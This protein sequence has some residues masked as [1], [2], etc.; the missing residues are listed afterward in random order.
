MAILQD[1]STAARRFVADFLDMPGT[2]LDVGRLVE[3][4]PNHDRPQTLQPKSNLFTSKSPV[5]S[6]P[7]SILW[8]KTDPISPFST[9]I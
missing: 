8:R 7:P 1:I 3:Q 6:N 4:M 2:N 9:S 5:R